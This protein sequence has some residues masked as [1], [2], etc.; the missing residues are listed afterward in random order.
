VAPASDWGR[1][2]DG[3]DRHRVPGDV[4]ENAPTLQPTP[5]SRARTSAYR[6]C[7]H[8][9]IADVSGVRARAQPRQSLMLDLGGL[10]GSEDPLEAAQTEAVYGCESSGGRSRQVVVDDGNDLRFVESVGE[11]PCLPAG[12]PALRP[13]LH[14][15]V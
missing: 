7:T 4:G 14:R 6:A 15:C 12:W 11:V 8:I 5:G 10:G 3:V 13:L 9:G 2:G 1:G